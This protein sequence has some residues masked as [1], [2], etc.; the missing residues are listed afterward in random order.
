MPVELEAMKVKMNGCFDI[1]KMLEEF[2]Y[3]FSKDEMQRRWNIFAAPREIQTM[4]DLRKG[5]I[6][7]LKVKYAEEMKVAQEE[8]KETFEN[9][10]RTIQNFH[11]HQNLNQHESVA[12][13][14]VYVQKQMAEFQEQARLFNVRESYFDKE[15]T[16]YSRLSTMAR[17]FQPYVNLWSTANR[18]LKGHEKWLHDPWETVD[19]EEAE[20]LVEEGTKNLGQVVRYMRDRDILGVMKIADSVKSQLEEF[21]PKVP[22]LS[23]LRKKGMTDR[24]WA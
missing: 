2:N 14:V 9:L 8:F 23:A 3:K 5:Q 16:D 13:I 1:F 12:E 18:W 4:V 24:H 15:Q 7:K 22:L 20:K 17:D 10:E 21:K 19:A 6:D 11:H